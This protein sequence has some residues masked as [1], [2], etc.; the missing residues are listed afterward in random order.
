[1]NQNSNQRCG[2]PYRPKKPVPPCVNTDCG[3]PPA[4]PGPRYPGYPRPMPVYSGSQRPSPMNQGGQRFIPMN[5]EGQWTN[6]ASMNSQPPVPLNP[7]FYRP[8][9]MNS[10]AQISPAVSP[11][12][13]IPMAVSSGVQISTDT[14]SESQQPIQQLTQQPIQQLTQ[15]PVIPA[16]SSQNTAGGAFRP[17]F[18]LNRMPVGMGYVPWQFWGQTYPVEQALMRGTIFPVLDYPFVMGRCR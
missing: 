10:G 7:G 2:C 11:G 18:E 1:M 6:P 13:Q 16:P 14:S 8:F 15:Q 12:A 17:G 5:Q 9:P 4:M 3:M